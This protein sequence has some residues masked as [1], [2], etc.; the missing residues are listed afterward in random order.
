MS[1]ARPMRRSRSRAPP[2]EPAGG[3]R[4]VSARGRKG[5]SGFRALPRHE[6]S[7]MCS[8]AFP[9]G[10][11]AKMRPSNMTSTRSDSPRISPNSAETTRT[12][13]PLSRSATSC[14]WICSVAPTSSPR[15][16]CS[17]ISAGASCA[18][19]RATTI[20]CRL[21]PDSVPTL[22]RSFAIWMAKRRMS[23]RAR[24]ANADGWTK[25]PLA[26]GGLRWNPIAR[27]SAALASAAEPT[28]ARS[29]GM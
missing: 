1:A 26:S 21:P 18:S 22:T 15:V 6:Q 29:S 25:G 5:S 13:R 2:A 3:R 27:L 9:R 12:A 23:A 11:S 19:S 16:G 20:F 14:S 17:A 24:S 7:D 8:S 4:L 28:A 10:R